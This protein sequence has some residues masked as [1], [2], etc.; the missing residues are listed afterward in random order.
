MDGW[1]IDDD[2][3]DD[4]ATWEW[5]KPDRLTD[6]HSPFFGLYRIYYFRG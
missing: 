3:D 1:M 6:Q 2:D 5:G 4:D